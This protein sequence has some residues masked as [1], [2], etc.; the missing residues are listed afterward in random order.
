VSPALHPES[1]LALRLASA[2][3]VVAALSLSVAG[4]RDKR[5]EPDEP[6]RASGASGAGSAASTAGPASTSSAS[7]TS[8]SGPGGAATAAAQ[9]TSAATLTLDG[10]PVAL[11]LALVKRRPDGSLQLYAGQR[12]ATCA[13][14]QDNLFSG[15]ASRVLVDLPTRLAPDGT[16][17]LAVGDLHHGGPQTPDPGARAK[18]VG[19]LGARGE[20]VTLELAAASRSA[21]LSLE[22]TVVAESCGD[23]L[24]TSGPGVPSPA[25]A[26]SATLTVAGKT[27]ALRGA[28]VRGESFELTD[29]PRDCSTAWFLGARLEAKGSSLSLDGK[30]FAE[31]IKA[32]AKGLSIEKSPKPPRKH[33]G[34]DVV[35]LSLSGTTRLGAYELSLS[36]TMEALVCPP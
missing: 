30:R 14:L 18:L 16:E 22:G 1:A 15:G 13:M 7:S 20:R 25:L 17:A 28:L 23:E 19:A 27:L 12:G 2:L 11:E 4:C 10:K 35:E 8:K 24:R 36:G 5:R 32:D 34:L 21:G 9:A 31:A 6:R 29:F 26:T 33:E 3:G